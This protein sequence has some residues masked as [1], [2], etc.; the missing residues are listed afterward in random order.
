MA[1][2]FSVSA[3]ELD[4]SKPVDRVRFFAN[5]RLL[6]A[7]KLID[8][9]IRGWTT[10]DTEMFVVLRK[11]INEVYKICC[12][13]SGD[14]FQSVARTMYSLLHNLAMSF[15]E[16]VCRSS[17]LSMS[18]L[19]K[20]IYRVE[21]EMEL[22][23]NPPT[24]VFTMRGRDEDCIRVSEM[25]K[26][27]E[28]SLAKLEALRKEYEELNKDLSCQFDRWLTKTSDICAMSQVDALH[29][30]VEGPFGPTERNYVN[31]RV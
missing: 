31:V 1:S 30:Y 10:L 16:S 2:K 19:E 17:V 22:M 18:K 3:A 28:A 13:A 12:S 15:V 25:L 29:A 6:F 5:M 20:A 21:C 27:P 24:G 9:E 26:T 14:E 23:R 11:R 7:R 4:G 8:F